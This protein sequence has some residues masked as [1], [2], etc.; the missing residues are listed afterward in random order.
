[1]RPFPDLIA[2]S[3]R[4]LR[5]R[6]GA[7]ELTPG[8]SA[9]AIGLVAVVIAL[10]AVGAVIGYKLA[11]AGLAGLAGAAAGAIVLPVLSV[12]ALRVATAG[13]PVTHTGSLAWTEKSLL[14]GYT[15]GVYTVRGDTWAIQSLGASDPSFK[16]GYRWSGTSSP[17]NQTR[18]FDF[19]MTDV[20]KTVDDVL[21]Q[22]DDY[23]G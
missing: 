3:H 7:T 9:T 4:N 23:Y 5:I 2:N 18:K 15:G 11:G 16:S 8:E 10:P 22:I 17:G 19:P 1:M 13:K 6:V 12:A 14:G 20:G 21:A